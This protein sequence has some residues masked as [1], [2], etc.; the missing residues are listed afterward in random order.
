MC[1]DFVTNPQPLKK[2]FGN[3]STTLVPDLYQRRSTTIVLHIHGS[4]NYPSIQRKIGKRHGKVVRLAFSF[5]S[6]QF[7]GL[8]WRLLC[9]S[10][11]L[12]YSYSRSR[13]KSNY[14]A[15]SVPS[16][17]SGCFSPGKT[18]RC[19]IK[20]LKPNSSRNL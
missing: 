18:D 19:S 12:F 13:M 10:S 7:F 16:F 4:F 17:F 6:E 9:T 11:A 2:E 1:A 15:F 20:Q 5:Y 8:I 14:L 3:Y